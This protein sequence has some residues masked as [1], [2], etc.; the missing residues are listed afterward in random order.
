M[1]FTAGQGFYI[2]HDCSG[3]AAL[4]VGICSAGWAA[5]ER[6]AWR[7]FLRVV[8]FRFKHFKR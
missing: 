3:Y 1:V 2:S 5:F 7:L 8:K 6:K 4:S